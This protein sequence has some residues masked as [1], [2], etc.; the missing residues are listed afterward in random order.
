[1]LPE[2]RIKRHEETVARLKE[3]IDWLHETGFWTDIASNADLI[4]A[5]EKVVAHYVSLVRELSRVPG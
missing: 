5:N 1:M 4:E 3:D 2:N